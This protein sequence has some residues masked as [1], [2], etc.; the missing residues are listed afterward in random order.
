MTDWLEFHDSTLT[1]FA[2]HD[3]RIELLLDAYI[4][5]WEKLDDEWRG[6]GWTQPVS[7]VVDDSVGGSFA[8]PTLPVEISDG[9]LQ[10][11]TTAANGIVRLPLRT[12]GVV[13]MR[14]ELSTGDIVELAGREVRI[15]VTAP[16]RY[17]EDLPLDLRPQE[18]D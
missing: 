14:L 10:L 13:K 12:S 15:E 9:W 1:W 7:I 4:H 6:T 17:V 3:T 8:L 18:P 5:R 2:P 11:G 16:A